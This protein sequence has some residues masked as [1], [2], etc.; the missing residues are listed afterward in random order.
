[1]PPPPPFTPAGGYPDGGWLRPTA[2]HM[3]LAT[4]GTVDQFSAACWYFGQS[5]TD[6][7]VARG[8][9]V[10][11]LGLVTSNWGGTTVQ[12][13]T[14]VDALP[15]CRNAS[16]GT[17][18]FNR[19][20]LANGALYAGMVAPFVNMTIKGAVWYQGCVRMHFVA[21]A[22]RSGVSLLPLVCV[23]HKDPS[24]L[25]AVAGRTTC[26]SAIRRPQNRHKAAAPRRAAQ[27][28]S[29][30]G[31]AATCSCWSRSGEGSGRSNRGP[32]QPISRL[33]SCRWR[34]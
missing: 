11:P 2:D 16:G 9:T 15:Q 5:L 27:R 7:W 23:W 12:Q 13:W 14:P 10:V 3:E 30:P 24:S 31:T 22:A 32:R 6:D 25:A 1:M 18:V 26:A 17:T 33:G 21:A 20:D 28:A 34:R 4:P 19:T 8:E 29:R